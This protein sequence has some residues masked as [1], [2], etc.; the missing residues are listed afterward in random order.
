MTTETALEQHASARMQ[1]L[2]V[3]K[4]ATFAAAKAVATNLGAHPNF[5]ITSIIGII[6]QIFGAFKLCMPTAP[7][8]H[9]SIANPTPR[10]ERA[11]E[12]VVRRN[13]R[14]N[15]AAQSAVWDAIKE[16]GGTLQVD[17]T[18]KIYQEA[19]GFPPTAA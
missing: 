12:R 2:A 6:G 10:E 7:A 3:S 18:S 15:P 11:G 5:D 14:G 8:V 19:N 4:P 13:Y 1:Q 17:D 16:V 9:Q